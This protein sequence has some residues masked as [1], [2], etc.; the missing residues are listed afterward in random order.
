MSITFSRCQLTA[1][2]TAISDIKF[3]AKINKKVFAQFFAAVLLM[4]GLTFT[5]LALATPLRLEVGTTSGAQV[6]LWEVDESTAFRADVALA[7]R[8]AD[9]QRFCLDAVQ[10]TSA[11]CVHTILDGVTRTEEAFWGGVAT[12]RG[13][14]AISS[15][16]IQVDAGAPMETLYL[17]RGAIDDHS[18]DED[19]A[20]ASIIS[21]FLWTREIVDVGASAIDMLATKLRNGI[22]DTTP[23]APAAATNTAATPSTITLD[24][25]IGNTLAQFTVP[26]ALT[27]AEYFQWA[28]QECSNAFEWVGEQRACETH[29]P[30]KMLKTM[31]RPPQAKMAPSSTTVSF[32]FSLSLSLPSLSLSL[33]LYR[34]AGNIRMTEWRSTSLT[35]CCIVT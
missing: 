16:N 35:Q 14:T 10:S 3:K 28:K 21:S 23:A 22:Q 19:A 31:P 4:L 15:V 9:A 7:A 26:I 1:A 5:V 6:L 20:I 25:T 12:M 34:A 32:F 27:R 17:H 29:L 11:A 8:T 2:S 13:V 24:I 30:R 18:G 33:S